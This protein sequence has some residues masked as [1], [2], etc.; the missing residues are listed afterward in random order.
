MLEY[1]LTHTHTHTYTHSLFPLKH[2]HAT[3]SEVG[4]GM[5]TEGY[6][7]TACKHRHN[8]RHTAYRHR[9]KQTQTMPRSDRQL[10]VT[11]TLPRPRTKTS[12]GCSTDNAKRGTGSF[13]RSLSKP[14]TR[15]PKPSILNFS[16]DNAKRG[17]GS[18]PEVYGD[19]PQGDSSHLGPRRSAA[20]MPN[21]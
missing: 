2:V 15:N 19:Q 13:A 4:G 12:E 14:E 5:R 3:Q 20:G 1:T 7:H 18:L 8:Q 11:L 21:A 17:T 10:S 6:T 16:T 9:H